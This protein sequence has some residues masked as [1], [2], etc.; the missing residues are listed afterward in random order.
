M[1]DLVFWVVCGG[2]AGW[3][4]SMV[5]TGGHKLSPFGFIIIGIIGAV[6]G[7]LFIRST[8][9]VATNGQDIIST[10]S[11]IFG[12]VLLVFMLLALARITTAQK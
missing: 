3:I 2:L 1:L 10:V 8:G 4:A 7:G 11:A 5:V 6:L 12:S 9:A